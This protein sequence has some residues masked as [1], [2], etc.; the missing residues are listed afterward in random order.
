MLNVRG[1]SPENKPHKENSPFAEG[2]G[3]YESYDSEYDSEP[4]HN[5]PNKRNFEREQRKG[6]NRNRES[7]RDRKNFR[8]K[9]NRKKDNEQN[10]PQ[11]QDANSI[12]MFYMQGKC[13]KVS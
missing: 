13:H 11:M 3:G 2:E 7:R 6:R 1:G 8:E 9:N 5:R 12:C 4:Y 10:R